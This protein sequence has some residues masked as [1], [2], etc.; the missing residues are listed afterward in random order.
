VTLRA[1]RYR[2]VDAVPLAVGSAVSGRLGRLTVRAVDRSRDGVLVDVRSVYLQRLMLT[3][4]DLFGSGGVGSAE[5]LAIRN[6][7]QKQAILLAG[8]SSRQFQYSLMSGLSSSQLGTGAR[9][10]RFVVPLADEDRVKIDDEWLAGAELVVL[11]PED[12]GAFTK[13][14][15]VERVNLDNAK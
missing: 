9:R 8:E 11:R 5:H 15:R 13:P 2:V 3:P 10:M 12:L 7:S 14:L 1:W 4:G 6:T